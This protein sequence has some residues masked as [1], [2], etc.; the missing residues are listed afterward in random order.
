[1]KKKI[2]FLLPNFSTGGAEKVTSILANEFA[3]KGFSIDLVLLDA[4][5]ELLTTL[6]SR[7]NVIDLKSSRIRQGFLPLLQYL[8]AERPDTLLA[9]MWPLTLLAVLAF[10]LANLPGRVVVSDRTTYSQS[11][12]LKS[13]LNRFIFKSSIPLIYP[14]ANARLAVSAGVADDLSNLSRINRDNITV[15]HNPISQNIPAFSM[16][17][18]QTAWQ[19]F[20]GKKI[21][22]VGSLKW[23]KNYPLLL[24]AFAILLQKEQAILT[25]VGQGELLSELELNAKKLGIEA[26]VQFVG[27][28]KV[29][30][31]W[32]ASADLF[33]LSSHYE[34]L[35]N[36]IIESLAMGTPI[37]STDC[38]SGPREILCDGKYGKL[39]PVNDIDAFA[40]AMLQSLKEE[41]DIEGL[42]KRAADFSVDKIAAQ[43]LDIMFPERLVKND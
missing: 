26:Y 8:K 15:V 9:L 35:P 40:Q 33:V 23:A 5:G 24:Q 17:Q 43:Y 7:I 31:K 12:L 21:V 13:R 30:Q 19:N 18:Q 16:Q 29:P 39:V 27:F 2:A 37:V 14:L 34:G 32:I 41:H 4:H 3:N 11:P 1:M 6:D 38:K 22:A 25:I 36:V 10:K 28:S 42:K 20:H